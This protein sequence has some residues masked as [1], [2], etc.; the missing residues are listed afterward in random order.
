[1]GILEQNK[2]TEDVMRQWGVIHKFGINAHVSYDV[3]NVRDSIITSGFVRGYLNSERYLIKRDHTLQSNV[4]MYEW[5]EVNE[6]AING[7][8]RP[9]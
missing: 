1:M 8:V 5:D 7:T 4:G 3:V 6:D 9:D 2:A